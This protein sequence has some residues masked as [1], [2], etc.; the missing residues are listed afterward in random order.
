M[1]R[2]REVKKEERFRENLRSLSRRLAHDKRDVLTRAR[3]FPQSGNGGNATDPRGEES[4]SRDV[5]F[6]T[7]IFFF[8][9]LARRKNIT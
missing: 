2:E 3:I 4:C 9:F 8:F 1:T 5:T 7:K 6:S